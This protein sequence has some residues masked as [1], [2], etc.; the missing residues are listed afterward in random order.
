MSGIRRVTLPSG[1]NRSRPCSHGSQARL[2]AMRG[3]GPGKGSAL[4]RKSMIQKGVRSPKPSHPGRDA[5]HPSPM[6]VAWPSLAPSDGGAQ[7]PFIGETPGKG[8]ETTDLIGVKGCLVVPIWRVL[9]SGSMYRR[10]PLL[11]VPYS[12]PALGNIDRLTSPRPP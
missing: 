2:W 3:S 9:P 12:G 7:G 8:T 1:E 5:R 6:V 10:V 4:N 11:R